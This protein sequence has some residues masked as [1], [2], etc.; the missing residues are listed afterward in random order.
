M[1]DGLRF[2]L[3]GGKNIKIEGVAERDGWAYL[4]E[5]AWGKIFV[6]LDPFKGE[7]IFVEGWYGETAGSKR[8]V[9]KFKEE[10]LEKIREF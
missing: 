8:Y 1:K 9:Y 3:E 7:L 6:F 10:E 4:G 2:R 5:G